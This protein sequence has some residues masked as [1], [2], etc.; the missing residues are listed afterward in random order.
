MRGKSGEHAVLVQTADL[1]GIT[2]HDRL[3][4]RDLTVAADDDTVA[5]PDG[6]NRGLILIQLAPE[7][8]RVARKPYWGPERL[9][10]TGGRSACKHQRV[11][12]LIAQPGHCALCPAADAKGRR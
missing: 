1:A 4:D 5:A 7:R 8:T 10:S 2:F 11:D 12:V 6:Q 9:N 3:T